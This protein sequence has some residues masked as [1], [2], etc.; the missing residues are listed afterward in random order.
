MIYLPFVSLACFSTG[1]H[2]RLIL[3]LDFMSGPSYIS[4]NDWQELA[5]KF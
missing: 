3:S 5:L 4:I 1:L 2:N